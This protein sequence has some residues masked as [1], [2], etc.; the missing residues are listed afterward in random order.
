MSQ[1]SLK[2]I[3]ERLER[4][5]NLPS[6]PMRTREIAALERLINTG[7]IT[8]KTTRSSR[9]KP[10][11]TIG[12]RSS[13]DYLDDEVEESPAQSRVVEDI[14]T[15]RRIIISKKGQETKTED[16]EIALKKQRK[17]SLSDIQTLMGSTFRGFS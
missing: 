11:S 1:E 6:T 5:R 13:H 8:R 2:E 3:K 12:S 14:G 10:S 4:L 7:A 17:Q 16:D 15:H 9:K